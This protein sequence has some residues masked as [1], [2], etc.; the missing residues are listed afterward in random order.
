MK[1]MKELEEREKSQNITTNS[2]QGEEKQL[3]TEVSQK[4]KHKSYSNGGRDK[5]LRIG[6]KKTRKMLVPWISLMESL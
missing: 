4:N 1:K 2:P 3:E 6:K 5:T